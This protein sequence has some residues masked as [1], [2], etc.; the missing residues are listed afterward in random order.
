MADDIA[1]SGKHIL[2]VEDDA[3]TRSTWNVLLSHKGYVVQ[4]AANGEAGLAWLSGNELP[5]VVI[6]DW[7]LPDMNGWE[8]L[9]RVRKDPE[10]AAL[11]VVVLSGYPDLAQGPSL[12]SGVPLLTKPVLPETLLDHL[13]DLARHPPAQILLVEDESAVS[14]VVAFLLRHAGFAVRQVSSGRKAVEV[15]TRH[16]AT[17][18]LVLMDVRMRDMDGPQTLAALQAVDPMVRVVFMSGHTGEYTA[19]D[20]LSRGALRVLSKPLPGGA[21]LT[22]LLQDLL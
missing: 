15:Y 3:D 2:L 6:L 13:H 4:Q 20:L 16:R 10:L 9:K 22:R 18:R 8:F 14:D 1:P 12:L 11:P 5:D 17:I 7:V 21:E 19:E